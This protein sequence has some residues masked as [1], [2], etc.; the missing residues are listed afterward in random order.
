MFLI[1]LLHLSNVIFIIFLCIENLT[2]S[3]SVN[4]AAL[5]PILQTSFTK[6][7]QFLT[8]CQL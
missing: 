7:N 3:A 4:K 2:F 8:F 1:I 6:L 5:N